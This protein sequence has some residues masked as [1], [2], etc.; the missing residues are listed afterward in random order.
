MEWLGPLIE[1]LRIVWVQLQS[2]IPKVLGALLLFG[3]GWALA[4]VCKRMLV[5]LMEAAGLER[6][7]AKAKISEALRRGAIRSSFVELLG[8]LGYW[9]VLVAAV[10]VSLQWMGVTAA[11]EWLQRFGAFLPRIII[12]LVMFLFG[13]LLAA[14]LGATVRAASLN[15]GIAQ[16]HLVGQAVYT[17]ALLV[18]IIVSLEQLQVVTRTIQVALYILMATFGLA[19]ALALGLGA[20]GLMKRFLEELVW[21]KWKS[22]QQR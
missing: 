18:T 9:L 21:E 17:V 5:R 6:L 2:L 13:T 12:S 7:A 10:I 11:E 19:F 20:Q 14:F 4:G 16:G 1:P 3:G 8:R 22:S 15:A